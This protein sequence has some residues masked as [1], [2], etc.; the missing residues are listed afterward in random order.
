MTRAPIYNVKT[1]FQPVTATVFPSAKVPNS[2]SSI[3]SPSKTSLVKIYYIT[4]RVDI[5]ARYFDKAVCIRYRNLI[6]ANYCIEK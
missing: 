3:Y 1:Q 2:L 5:Y 6:L 4:P